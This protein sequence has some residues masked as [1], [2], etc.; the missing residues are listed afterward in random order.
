MWL[1]TLASAFVTGLVGGLHCIGMCG[2]F[3]AMA[4]SRG[5]PEGVVLYHTGRWTTYA[6]LGAGAGALGLGL[7]ALGWVGWGLSVL[8]LLVL[9]LKLLGW[10]PVWSGAGLP[11]GRWLAGWTRRA[12]PWAPFVLG[13]STAL[14]PCGLVYTALALPVASGSPALGAAA[15]VAFGMG[16]TPLLSLASFGARSKV[17]WQTPRLR[18]AL[19]L[20]LLVAGGWHLAE[21][22]PQ[23]GDEAPSCC[24][25]PG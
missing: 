15:M 24:Q 18:I 23:S 25:S 20:L 13:T 12:G 11:V 14:L 5:T 4:A 21:R 3:A 7:G 1:A 6:L 19:A 8:L 2:G 16:T 22:I 17:L 10:A 9:A